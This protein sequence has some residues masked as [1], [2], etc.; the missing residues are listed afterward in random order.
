M[1][2]DPD[3]P[4]L[5]SFFERIPYGLGRADPCIAC[6]NQAA[7]EPDDEGGIGARARLEAL[8]R[9]VD[10]RAV[11]GG[12]SLAE[13]EI[14]RQHIGRTAHLVGAQRQDFVE[15]P[16]IGCHVARG[17]VLT[18]ARQAV[19][20]DQRGCGQHQREQARIEHR[21]AELERAEAPGIDPE[22]QRDHR[23]RIPN[24]RDCAPLAMVT[25]LLI[26]LPGARS[27]GCHTVR[28]EVPAETAPSVI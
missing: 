17:A 6:R 20:G 22:R 5:A 21:N 15:H 1:P 4:A 16:R 14:A 11:A 12:K 13:A 25:A 24:R 28:G 7:I 2:A 9:A 26:S 10:R 19:I 27:R 3:D 23:R 8:Q 18:E